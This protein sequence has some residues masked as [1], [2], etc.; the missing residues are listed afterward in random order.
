[1]KQL[2][3]KKKRR[4]TATLS[5]GK[6]NWVILIIF[7]GGP[8]LRRKVQCSYIPTLSP[9]PPLSLSL[10]NTS[11]KLPP[12]SPIHPFF[13][14]VHSRNVSPL[15]GV[16]FPP[17]GLKKISLPTVPT[18]EPALGLGGLLV[19]L[20]VHLVD[21]VEDLVLPVLGVAL[22]GLLCLFEVLFGLIGL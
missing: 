22:G 13:F 16:P 9:Y 14:C 21:A 10:N 6:R 12:S 3:P 20:V 18:A 1:M 5:G 7:A 8:P 11:L 17:F 15:P 2:E 19:D 4:N